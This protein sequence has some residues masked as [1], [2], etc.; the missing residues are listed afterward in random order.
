MKLIFSFFLLLFSLAYASE[1][2][3]VKETNFGMGISYHEN[4]SI[5]G[6]IASASLAVSL[7][8]AFGISLLAAKGDTE[9]KES[10]G[11]TQQ[12]ILGSSLFIRD[13]SLG[14]LGVS[15]QQ[16]HMEYDLPSYISNM[17]IFPKKQTVYST[18]FYAQYFLKDFTLGGQMI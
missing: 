2:G 8:K 4:D 3:G 12:S 17:I 5:K 13:I 6:K 10:W 1:T 16:N 18:T 11:D 9:T 7:Y 15:Y 14:Q